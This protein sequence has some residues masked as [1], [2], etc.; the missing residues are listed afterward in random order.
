MDQFVSANK[1]QS[2]GANDVVGRLCYHAENSD[3]ITRR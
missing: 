2:R 3:N 1:G